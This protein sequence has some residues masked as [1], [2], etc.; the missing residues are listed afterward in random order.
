[1]TIFVN[2]LNF[3]KKMGQQ[4]I[5][6]TQGHWLLAKMGKKVLRPGGRIL[7]QQ[8]LENLNIGRDDDIIEFAPGTGYTSVLVQRFMPRSYTGVELN[9]EAAERLQKKITGKNQKI[10]V[11]NAAQVPL[12]DGVANKVYGEAMLTMQADHRKSEII[13]EAHRLLKKGGLYGIHE[14]GLSPDNMEEKEKAAIQNKL[15]KTIK[16]NARPLTESEWVSLL[17]Q[18]G[19]MIKTVLHRPMLLL[20]ARRVLEDEGFLNTL[21][22][23]ANILSHPR[24]R[25]RILEMRQLF[26]KYRKEL[27][28]IVVIA[29]KA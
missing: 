28:A 14:L 25:K 24:E 10:L 27:N 9:E 23:G 12:K 21:K 8:L 2:K 7:T 18:E 20:E 22:I 11:A 3:L 13:R 15:A 26:K 17:K 4:H 5:N 1:M 6:A 16:V 19:F 29:E